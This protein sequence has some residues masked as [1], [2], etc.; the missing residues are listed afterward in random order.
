M[1]HVFFLFFLLIYI[2]IY[3]YIYV[4]GRFASRFSRGTVLNTLK[5]SRINIMRDNIYIYIYIYIYISVTVVQIL[6]FSSKYFLLL[7]LIRNIF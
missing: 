3:I 5:Q 4:C 2:Y 7:T 1:Q 6:P